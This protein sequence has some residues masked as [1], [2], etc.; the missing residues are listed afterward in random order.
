VEWHGHNDRGLAAANSLAAIAAG[1][2]QIHATAVSLGERIGNTPTE[3]VLVNLRLLDLVDR[4]LSKL[5]QYSE[6]VAKA[7]HTLIPPSYP[8]IGRDAFRTATGVHAAAIVKA[9]KKDDHELADS[10]YSGVPSRMI[11]LEQ[12]IEVGP[13][14]GRSNVLYWLEKH[15]ILAT[16]ELVDRIYSA[17][18]QSE[19]V[20]TEDEIL[21]L[22]GSLTRRA[23]SH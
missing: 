13:M 7:A 9:F 20:L 19:H 22:V 8:V 3:L 6:A 14:S 15:G 17:A 16:D 23:K 11:G 2:D 12:V 1:A 18:K 5:R 21:A 10:V 4:D